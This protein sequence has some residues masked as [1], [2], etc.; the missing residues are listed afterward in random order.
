MG[1]Q[2]ISL[3]AARV[4][5]KMTQ[6]QTAKELGVTKKTIQNW[7]SGKTSPSM[8]QA[9]AIQA[10]FRYPLSLIFFSQGKADSETIT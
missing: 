1:E 7:E 4:N 3:R 5:A 10:L 6:G 9:L 8:K 2:K